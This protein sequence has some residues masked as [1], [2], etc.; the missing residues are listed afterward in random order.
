MAVLS[1]TLWCCSLLSYLSSDMATDF[2]LRYLFPAGLLSPPERPSFQG[3]SYH[4]APDP[5][6]SDDVSF[7]VRATFARC[8]I[9]MPVTANLPES[10]PL[11]SG[12]ALWPDFGPYA[13]SSALYQFALRH[14]P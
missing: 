10:F 8:V 13:A 1:S 12:G 7:G 14:V 2:C 11:V 4:V 9:F 6:L 3:S 5:V